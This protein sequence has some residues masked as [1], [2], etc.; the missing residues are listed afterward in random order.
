MLPDL[1]DLDP[2]FKPNSLGDSLDV[3]ERSGRAEVADAAE[4]LAADGAPPGSQDAVQAAGRL[5]GQLDLN[6][7]ERAHIAT[8]SLG[9]TPKRAMNSSTSKSLW[10]ILPVLLFPGILLPRRSRRPL[11]YPAATSPP[12]GICPTTQPTTYASHGVCAWSAASKGLKPAFQGEVAA[13]AISG[14]LSGLWSVAGSGFQARRSPVGAHKLADSRCDHRQG[15]Y[16]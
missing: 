4:L 13:D 11:R 7:L 12:S 16:G 8:T 10:L 6:R 2:G 14:P 9:T 1:L 5:V 3:G 15:L